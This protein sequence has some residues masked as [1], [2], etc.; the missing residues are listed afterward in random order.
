MAALRQSEQLLDERRMAKGDKVGGLAGRVLGVVEW[1]GVGVGTECISVAFRWRCS[2][3]QI[4]AEAGWV[5]KKF[6]K[7][8]GCEHKT[9]GVSGLWGGLQVICT[10]F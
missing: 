8:Q 4:Y 7:N 3:F 10:I 6:T 5:L 2:K 9:S 1:G